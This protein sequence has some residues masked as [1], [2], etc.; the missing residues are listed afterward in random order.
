MKYPPRKERRIATMT[1]ESFSNG[2]LKIVFWDVFL[3]MIFV[4]HLL[5]TEQLYSGTRKNEIFPRT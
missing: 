2:C 5:S 3:P 1:K 4:F